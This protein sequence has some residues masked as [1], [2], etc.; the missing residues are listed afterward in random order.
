[1]CTCDYEYGGDFK[2][3]R[4][5]GKNPYKLW[6]LSIYFHTV[7]VLNYLYILFVILVNEFWEDLMGNNVLDHCYRDT[8]K[9][10]LLLHFVKPILTMIIVNCCRLNK[11]CCACSKVK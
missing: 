5:T 9:W 8:V 4:I 6:S 3:P 2:N 10:W 7:Y 1:M 11:I